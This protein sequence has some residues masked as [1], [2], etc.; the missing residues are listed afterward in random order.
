MPP[1]LPPEL[2]FHTAPAPAP[3]PDLSL[4]PGGEVLPMLPAA[5]AFP[6]PVLLTPS[7]PTICADQTPVDAAVATLEPTPPT[8]SLPLPSFHSNQGS[9]PGIDSSFQSQGPAN[10]VT[11]S[12][13]C[14]V[15]GLSQGT[16][17]GERGPGVK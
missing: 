9:F 12:V 16:G 13:P 4:N 10:D 14:A 15:A 8:S 3:A 7:L 11:A 5:T 17:E 1:E 2:S 6:P